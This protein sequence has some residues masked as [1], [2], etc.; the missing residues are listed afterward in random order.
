MQ[1]TLDVH[2]AWYHGAT[3]A[4]DCPGILVRVVTQAKL[5]MPKDVWTCSMNVLWPSI[6]SDA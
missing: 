2:G 4:L 6:T 5:S 1:L 3:P